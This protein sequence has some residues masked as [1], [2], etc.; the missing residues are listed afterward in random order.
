MDPGPADV[1]TVDTQSPRKDAGDGNDTAVAIDTNAG[2]VDGGSADR[3]A[4]AD[5][6]G[7][8]WIQLFNGRDLTGWRVKIAGYPVDQNFGDTFRVEDGVLKV[9]YDKYQGFG[10]HFGHLFIL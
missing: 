8:D 10:G 3:V 2:P 4:A 5:D 9:K 6:A 7:Q 1:P